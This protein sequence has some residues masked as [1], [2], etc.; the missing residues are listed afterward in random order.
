[1]KDHKLTSARYMI[2]EDLVSSKCV[3]GPRIAYS[4]GTAI[5]GLYAPRV[6]V[7]HP[8]TFHYIKTIRNY[9]VKHESDSQLEEMH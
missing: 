1:M 6:Y 9:H 2:T 7:S 4:R 8:E 3:A 5:A